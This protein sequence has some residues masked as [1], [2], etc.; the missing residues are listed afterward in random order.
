MRQNFFSKFLDVRAERTLD[1]LE[2][3][4]MDVEALTEGLG[5]ED[6]WGSR[7]KEVRRRKEEEELRMAM[8]EDDK[9]KRRKRRRSRREGGREGGRRLND[10]EMEE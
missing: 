3:K 10:W 1:Q 5:E 2:E 9:K 8:E 4:G 7:L 6:E